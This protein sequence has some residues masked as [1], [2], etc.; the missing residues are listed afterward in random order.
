MGIQYMASKYA[1]LARLD[2]VTPHTLRHTFGKNLVDAGVSLDR[3][4][5][6]LGHK[7]LN[8]TRLYT[9]PSEADL[10]QAVQKLEIR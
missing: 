1:Y 8:T 4:A 2:H 3:V 10:A 9:K 5:M 6:L 7:N